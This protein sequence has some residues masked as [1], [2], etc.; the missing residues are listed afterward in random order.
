MSMA[1]PES[2]INEL[3]EL[4]QRRRPA[5]AEYDIAT[6]RE[7]SSPILTKHTRGDQGLL[8]SHLACVAE[9][10]DIVELRGR[11][12]KMQVHEDVSS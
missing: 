9:H 1:G 12:L 6:L 2:A 7:L 8:E 4:D 10:V 3:L 5:R 11:A